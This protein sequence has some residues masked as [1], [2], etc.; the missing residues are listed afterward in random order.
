MDTEVTYCLDDLEHLE[1]PGVP[2]AVVG[3]PVA[4]SVSPA[5]HC[6]ALHK[7]EVEHPE[8]KNWAYYRFEIAPDEL[9]RALPLFHQKQ[10][11]GLNLTV[12]HKVIALDLVRD[13]SSDARLMGAVNTLVWED[14]GYLGHNTDGYGLKSALK[15]NLGITLRGSHVI[16]L[17]AGGA[18]RAAAVQCLLEGCERLY[19]ANRSAERL[20]GLLSVL[21]ELPGEAVKRVEIFD[22]SGLPAEL[23]KE[24]VLVNATSLGLKEDD[25][26][27]LNTTDLPIGWKVYDMIYNPP[28]TKL[29]KQISERGMAGANGL[30]MLVYQGARSLEIWSEQT[31]DAG[32]MSSAASQAL[33]LRSHEL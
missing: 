28:Q 1:F 32:V 5:M 16:L 3:Q 12:P 14:G 31:V 9:S 7:L 8:F 24:G 29:L 17:G 23:P 21:G 2:L 25:P 33:N 22:L 30:S 26:L 4:H 15:M 10:F 11:R 6:A 27:P 18:A 13:V 19:V 20:K